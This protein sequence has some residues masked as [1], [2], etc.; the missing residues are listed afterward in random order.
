MKLFG[1]LEDLFDRDSEAERQIL[2]PRPNPFDYQRCKRVLRYKP[3]HFAQTV[4]RIIEAIDYYMLETRPGKFRDSLEC[5]RVGLCAN[6]ERKE[7]KERHQSHNSW[8]VKISLESRVDYKHSKRA[9]LDSE[10][11]VSP[12]GRS[13]YL[14]CSCRRGLQLMQ[15]PGAQ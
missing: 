1:R 12:A 13:D 5:Q 2:Q 15:L 7:G 10:M 8:L 3:H 11:Q 9:A 4:W 14:K 6:N